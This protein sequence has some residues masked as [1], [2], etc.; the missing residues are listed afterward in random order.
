MELNCP[1]VF[2]VPGQGG[3]SA[4]TCNR[5]QTAYR[6]L[7]QSLLHSSCCKAASSESIPKLAFDVCNDSVV[8]YTLT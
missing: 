4:W 3:T 6:E 8:R 5:Y 7:Q 1:P 2:T